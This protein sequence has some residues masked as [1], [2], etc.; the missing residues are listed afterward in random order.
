MGD[1]VND[2]VICYEL[3]NGDLLLGGLSAQRGNQRTAALRSQ[4]GESHVWW[5]CLQQARVQVLREISAVTFQT[6]GLSFH[7]GLQFLWPCHSSRDPLSVA[8]CDVAGRSQPCCCLGIFHE[9]HS[10][11]SDENK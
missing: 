8:L 4:K 5:N 11:S 10:S 1:E 6:S 7:L 2:G 3:R 9:F